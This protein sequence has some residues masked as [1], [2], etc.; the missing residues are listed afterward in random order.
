M[1]ASP[2]PLTL[3]QQLEKTSE[4]IQALCNEISSALHIWSRPDYG[5]LLEKIEAEAEDFL[6]HAVAHLSTPHQRKAV[7]LSIKDRRDKLALR[8]GITDQIIS[9]CQQILAFGAA[10]LALTIG[11][12]DKVRL[13]SPGVQK[14]LTV[15]GI[16][17]TELVLISLL[18]LILYM[19]QARFRYPF[20]QFTKIGNTWSSFYYAS[21]SSRVPRSPIQT[22]HQII[23]AD[24]LYALDLAKFAMK[25]VTETPEEK[26][27]NDIR[28]YFLLIS[29]QGYVNQFSL[30]LANLFFYG[31]FG[32]IVGAIVL[33]LLFLSGTLR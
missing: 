8:T 28:Q 29:Y 27:R 14:A 26:L 25:C 22:A 11:F 21:I 7:C 16:F 30:R 12:I 23:L 20:L 4:K 15:G 5:L 32:A 31:F 19:L 2:A 9:I 17:Y 3:E 1:A 13:F 33:S 24:T 10:G 6:N 18:V